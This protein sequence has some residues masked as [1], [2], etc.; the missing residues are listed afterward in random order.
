MRLSFDGAKFKITMKQHC[1]HTAELSDD[2]VGNITRINNAL[3]KIPENLQ[4]HK[5]SL[6][7]LQKELE[8]A[9]EEAE[10]PFVQEEELAEK[11]ARLAEL[12][13]ALDQTEK[14]ADNPVKEISQEDPEISQDIPTREDRGNPILSDRKS[15]ILQTLK[16]YQAPAPT[17]SSA[18]HTREGR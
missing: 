6:D 4:R 8:S 7:R 16:E 10:R 9:K 1:T 3:E 11:I 18:E 12:N 14:E 2:I 5:D 15:S 17:K 13:T